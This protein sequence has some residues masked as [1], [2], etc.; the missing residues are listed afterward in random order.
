[1]F[2][3]LLLKVWDRRVLNES[4]P[5]PVGVLAGHADGI[6]HIDPRVIWMF[7]LYL[8]L[9]V[10]VVANINQLTSCSLFQC[11]YLEII[12]DTALLILFS[13]SIKMWW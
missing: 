10:Y 9:V 6:T 2:F 1:M 12:L 8:V 7:V 11:T 3:V 4:C 13:E 5:C